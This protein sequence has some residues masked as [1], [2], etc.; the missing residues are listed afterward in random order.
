GSFVPASDPER[1][2]IVNA[3]LAAGADPNLHEHRGGMTALMFAARQRQT[4]MVQA[5]IEH[6][7]EVNARSKGGLTV[8]MH[9]TSGGSP[10]V[11]KLLLA[12]GADLTAREYEKGYTALAI[13]RACRRPVIV[14]LLTAAGAKERAT[15]PLA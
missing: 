5:L 2:A 8:L 12:H 4:A 3:L 6:G 10:E 15:H 13:A 9:A 14:R 7:A 11:V 1:A